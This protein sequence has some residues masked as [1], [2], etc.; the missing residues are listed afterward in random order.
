MTGNY[1]YAT[2]IRDIDHL[3]LPKSY[4]TGYFLQSLS[5][6][7]RKAALLPSSLKFGPKTIERFSITIEIFLTIDSP[8]KNS[9]K[10]TRFSYNHIFDGVPT[11]I[12]STRQRD[13]VNVQVKVINIFAKLRPANFR[14]NEMKQI[15]VLQ[16]FILLVFSEYHEATSSIVKIA[17]RFQID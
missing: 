10:K 16:K 5:A 9:E 7:V 4:G 15:N 8:R 6:D 3:K 1:G 12:N 17:S 2:V 14:N 13:C 11:H